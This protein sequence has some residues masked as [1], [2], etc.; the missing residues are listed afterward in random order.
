MPKTHSLTF[1][2]ENSLIRSSFTKDEKHQLWKSY[3]FD[4]GRMQFSWDNE[5]YRQASINPD[6][7]NAIPK[8]EDFLPYPFRH[9]SATIVGG[10]TW[11][12]TE[13]PEKVLKPAAPMLSYRPV[14]VNHNLEISN[15]VAGIGKTKWTPGFTAPDGTKVPGGI[16]GPI[17]VDGKLHPDICRKLS[18]FPVPH[19]QSVSVTVVFEWEPSHTFENRE[20]E[21][22]LWLFEMRIGQMVDGEMVRRVATKIIEFYETSLVWLGADPFAKIMDTEGNLL[23][24]E[25]SAI[26][27][28]SKFDKD[29]LVNLYKEQ[30][31]YFV[32]ESCISNDNKLDL[33]KRIFEKGEKQEKS[34]ISNSKTQTQVNNPNNE[35]TMDD[36]VVQFLA[37]RLNKK[38]EEITENFLKGF[39]IVPTEEHTSLTALKEKVGSIEDY[40]KVVGD[41]DQFKTDL[42]AAQA[43]IEEDKP[44]VE[45]ATTKL[46]SAKENAF[47]FYRLQLNGR[48]EDA[49]AIKLIERAFEEKDFETMETLAKQYG[50]TA[51]SE[52]EAT[53]T[54]CGSKEVSFRSTEETDEGGVNG[55]DKYD[56]P[57]LAYEFRN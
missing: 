47:K 11:K 52:L 45:F 53:C 16:D 39:A 28:N 36:K 6:I 17:F 44:L 1:I 15:I 4:K 32:S 2:A 21:E 26:V 57:D 29:P 40:D 51:I 14:Y 55:D 9:L 7:Q 43:K 10:G 18:A 34:K 24:I 35:N 3:G 46:E 42:D 41:R 30:N 12:A 20:G 48:E 23:N 37:H 25:K 8:E 33:V 31:R 13:F 50:G 5:D 49:K 22:D 56:A 19:I 38:P 54:A 27:S